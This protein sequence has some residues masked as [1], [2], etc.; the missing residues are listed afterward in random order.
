MLLFYAAQK[1]RA[2]EVLE[3]ILTER[4]PAYKIMYC[5]DIDAVE[6]RLR[7]PRQNLEILLILVQDAI[8]MAR[9]T[10]MRALLLDMRLILVLPYRDEATVA[11]AHK[12]SPRFIAYADN[13]MEQLAPVLD[14]MLGNIRHLEAFTEI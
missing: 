8:E 10:Y 3:G 11:W 14:K 7:R 1:S 4:L 5:S 2:V 6:K 9:L 12:L 13:E